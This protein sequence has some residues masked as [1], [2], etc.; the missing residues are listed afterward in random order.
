M[1]EGFLVIWRDFENFIRG[2][3]PYPESIH[4]EAL[5]L[6]PQHNPLIKIAPPKARYPSEGFRITFKCIRSTDFAQIADL[7][8]RFFRSIDSG[9]VF[10]ERCP[11]YTVIFPEYEH[12]V[13]YLNHLYVYFESRYGL[14]GPEPKF[15]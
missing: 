14:F 1:A 8:S 13:K 12:A 6:D 10:L 7:L 9:L 4:S 2:F 11:I 3:Q 15:A 5:R